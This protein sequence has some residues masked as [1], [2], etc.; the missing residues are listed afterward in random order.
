MGGSDSLPS[1]ADAKEDQ[2]GPNWGGPE[3]LIAILVYEQNCNLCSLEIF[4]N[5]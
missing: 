4:I 3:T 1:L 2:E 5:I